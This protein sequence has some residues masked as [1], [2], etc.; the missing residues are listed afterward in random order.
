VR[1]N[2]RYERLRRYA[3]HC[4]AAL[5]TET[6]ALHP[7]SASVYPAP[8]TD[9]LLCCMYMQ[10]KDHFTIWPLGHMIESESDHARI[11]PWRTPGITYHMAPCSPHIACRSQFT[12]TK[13]TCTDILM[14]VEDL[15]ANLCPVHH[16]QPNIQTSCSTPFPSPLYQG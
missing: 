4:Y 9:N 8:S 16:T 14:H 12:E 7:A 2:T 6:C 13:N 1:C 5:Q 15:F 3:C 11:A 10:Y